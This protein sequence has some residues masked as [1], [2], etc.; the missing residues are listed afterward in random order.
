MDIKQS[1]GTPFKATATGATGLAA[2]ATVSA[3]VGSTHY[4]TDISAT[5]GVGSASVVVADGT[6]VIWQ[7]IVS[8]SD[9]LELNLVSP[10]AATQSATATITVVKASGSANVTANLGGYTL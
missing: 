6:T 8:S 4:V 10:L 5:V 2:T 3:I 9:A 1:R 7:G